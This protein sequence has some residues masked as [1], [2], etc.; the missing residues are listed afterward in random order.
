VAFLGECQQVFKAAKVHQALNVPY[1][2]AWCK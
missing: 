1:T 2:L